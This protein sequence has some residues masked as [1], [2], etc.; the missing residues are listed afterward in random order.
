[1]MKAGMRDVDD[2]EDAERD[3]DADRHRGIEAAEQDAGNQSR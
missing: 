3:R 1:M 2:V